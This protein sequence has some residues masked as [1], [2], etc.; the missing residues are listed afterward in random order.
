M[1]KISTTHDRKVTVEERDDST[2]TSV[3]LIVFLFSSDWIEQISY[4]K[5]G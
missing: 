3:S 2:F 4:L 5:V 1:K